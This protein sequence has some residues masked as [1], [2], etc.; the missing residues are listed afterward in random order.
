M[1]M[2]QEQSASASRKMPLILLTGFLILLW[3]AGGA[4]RADAAGQVV[5]R[6]GSWLILILAALVMPSLEWRRA[7]AVTLLLGL[8]ILLVAL[9]LLP[10][11]PGLWANLPGRELAAQAAKVIGEPQPWRPVSMSPGATINALSALVVPVVALVLMLNIGQ[12][13]S[14]RLISVILSLVLVSA[15]LGLVQLSGGRYDNPLIND[16]GGL[17]S[18]P[19]ANRN[20][21]ALMVAI[22]CVLLPA[23]SLRSGANRRVSIPI[24]AGM[25]IFFVFII[26]AIGSRMG[27]LLGV[28][29]TLLGFVAVRETL[30]RELRGVRKRATLGLVAGLAG[31]VL[32]A[33]AISIGFERADSLD[34]MMATE[35]S[36][37]LRARFLPVVLELIGIY[38][39]AGSGFGAFD[40]VF[41]IAE[42]DM[43]LQTSYVNHAHNDW[44]ELVLDGGL[45]AALLLLAAAAWWAVA[46]LRAWRA[47]RDEIFIARLGSAVIGLVMVASLADYPARTPFIMTLAMIAAVWLDRG[48]PS[49]KRDI[50]RI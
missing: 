4:S 49:G 24:A 5:V 1:P 20:H 30:S 14:W 32:L 2:R 11:P 31:A 8:S 47:G 3:F 34:R 37:D 19:F 7:R 18:G 36:A 17:V 25:L 6:G 29:G 12:K 27:I 40:P 10:L 50:E 23:W 35:A 41:R 9:H 26:L 48:T 42:P 45:P 22:G 21:F 43:L 16:I 15:V 46:S 38:F 39:P 28:A 33:V 13:Q 44:L